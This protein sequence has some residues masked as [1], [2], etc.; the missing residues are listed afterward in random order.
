MTK[1]KGQIVYFQLTCWLSTLFSVDIED[2]EAANYDAITKIHNH[3]DDDR[4]GEVDISESDGVCLSIIIDDDLIIK[5]WHGYDD[6]DNG[7]CYWWWWW[8]LLL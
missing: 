5:W 3:L 7:C 1:K 4:N 8:W 6:D 2:Y